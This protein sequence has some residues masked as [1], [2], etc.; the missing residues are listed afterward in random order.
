MENDDDDFNVCRETRSHL[1]RSNLWITDDDED[2]DKSTETMSSL[3]SEKDD[4]D[5]ICLD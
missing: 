3:D 1:M 5:I 4:D 2:E